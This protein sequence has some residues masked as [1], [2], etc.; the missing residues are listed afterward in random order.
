[1]FRHIVTQFDACP[2]N[3]LQ[4]CHVS[5]SQI[6]FGGLFGQR[7]PSLQ[8]PSAEHV[9]D[10]VENVGQRSVLQEEAGTGEGEGGEREG[11]RGGGWGRRVLSYISPIGAF[12]A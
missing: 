7:F 5:L 2:M 9:E 11:R 4:S 6:N 1:M 3:R 12:L 8:G 10:L